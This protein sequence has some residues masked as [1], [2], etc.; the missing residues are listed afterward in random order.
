MTINDVT[1][2]VERTDV[3]RTEPTMPTRRMIAIGATALVVAIVALVAFVQSSGDETVRPTRAAGCHSP[4][5]TSCKT[6][7]TA[8]SSPARRSQPAPPSRDDIVQDLVDRGLVPRQTLQPAPPSRDDIVQD[9]VDRG[10]VPAA[11]LDD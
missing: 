11:T 5:T 9:L 10:L 7:S 2:Q 3:L 1:I 4:A 8:D 6:S